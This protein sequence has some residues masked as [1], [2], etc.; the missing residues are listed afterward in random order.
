MAET[1]DVHVVSYPLPDTATGW[2][3]DDVK[4]HILKAPLNGEG[5]GITIVRA[6]AVNQAATGAG[7]SFSLALHNYDTH[8]TA[9]KSSGG[10]VAAAIG[11]TA[12]PWAAGVPK[13]FTLS[14]P[15]LGAGEWLVLDKQEDNSSDPTRGVVVI[16]YVMGR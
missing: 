5:G 4:G 13:E 3:G 7:T 6:Y 14:N 8:G 16:E 1:L 11:G 9:L 15:Y 2:Q 12:S 10:T